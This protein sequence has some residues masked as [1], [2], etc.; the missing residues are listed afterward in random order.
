MP[1]TIDMFCSHCQKEFKYLKKEHVRRVKAEKTKF[2]CSRACSIRM[3]NQNITSERRARLVK[4]F[5][6]ITGNTFGKKGRFVQY[7][8]KAKGRLRD[9]NLTDEYLETIWTG[10]CALSGIPIQLK[11]GIKRGRSMTMTSAS[12]DRK[13]SSKGYLKENVQFVAY[14]INLAKNS[15]SDDDVK[16]FLSKIRHKKEGEELKLASPSPSPRGDRNSPSSVGP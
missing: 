7:L 8:R 5:G 16:Q 12:L 11:E 4:N 13:D 1:S 10:R 9:F 3:N 2:Y 14:G 15:F 6:D